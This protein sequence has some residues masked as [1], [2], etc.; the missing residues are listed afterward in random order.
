MAKKL[1]IKIR[2]TKDLEADGLIFNQMVATCAIIARMKSSVKVAR[3]KRGCGKESVWERF[4]GG[5][6]FP[7]F[8]SA[9]RGNRGRTNALLQEKGSANIVNYFL[10][11]PKQQS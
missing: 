2:E 7:P 5:I 1:D 11:Y 10:Y 3:H 9:Q 8:G 6:R 4:S